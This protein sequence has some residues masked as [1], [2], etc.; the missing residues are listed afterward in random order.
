MSSLPASLL[1]CPTQHSANTMMD[2]T[3]AATEI[4]APGHGKTGGALTEPVYSGDK[5]SKTARVEL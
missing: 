2:N 5:F 1:G 3:V 4:I